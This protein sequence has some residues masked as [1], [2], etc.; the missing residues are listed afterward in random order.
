ME[1]AGFSREEEQRRR[2]PNVTSSSSY[3]TSCTQHHGILMD[4]ASVKSVLHTY[5]SSVTMF[6]NTEEVEVGEEEE[7]I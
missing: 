2:R 5:Q 1:E 3:F 7:V 4:V 6:D